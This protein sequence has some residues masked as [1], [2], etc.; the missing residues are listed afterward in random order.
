MLL[1]KLVMKIFSVSVF[2][3]S[4]SRLA[5]SA[6]QT[7][8]QRTERCAIS[9]FV[10]SLTLYSITLNPLTPSLLSLGLIATKTPLLEFMCPLTHTPPYRPCWVQAIVA[11]VVVVFVTVT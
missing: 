11:F 6:K 5:A 7:T 9:Y 2:F 4:C 3:L 8:T 10:S 1:M